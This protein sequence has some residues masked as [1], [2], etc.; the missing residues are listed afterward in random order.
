MDE[1]SAAGESVR[2]REVRRV[3][4][5]YL[6]EVVEAWGLCPWAQSSRLRGELVIE[7]CF[8]PVCAPSLVCERARAALAVPTAR[9]IMLVFPELAGG[10]GAIGA[11]RDQVALR[12]PEAGV[13]A[14]GP[15]SGHDLSSPAKLVPLLRC[16]PDPMLQLVPFWLLDEVKQPPAPISAL[17]QARALAGRSAPTAPSLVERIAAR[18]HEVVTADRA[19]R[20]LDTLAQIA[21]DRA[22]SYRR[23]GIAVAAP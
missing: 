4:E 22:T 18:N 16:A 17:E 3:L 15:A 10:S 13:A 12:V 6:I 21:D 19:Q 14:F 1:V 20:L 5:R 2:E 11:L 9:V 23:V 8:G 7:I